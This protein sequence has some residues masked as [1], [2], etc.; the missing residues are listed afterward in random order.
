MR[1]W[2]VVRALHTSAAALAAPRR[3]PPRRAQKHQ[4]DTVRTPSAHT[5]PPPPRPAPRAAD[6]PRAGELPALEFDTPAAAHDGERAFRAPPLSEGLLSM[7]HALLGRRARPTRPQSQALAHFFDTPRRAG[8]TVVAAETGS[9]KTLAYLLP[10]LQL[11]HTTRAA[12]E[13]AD[14]AAV[15]AGAAPRLMPRAVVLAPTHELARQIA[16][17]AKALCHHAEHKLRVDC[18]STRLFDERAA[19]AFAQLEGYA[20]A[21]HDVAAPAHHGAPLS[22]DVL[23]TTPKRLRE[24][25][26]TQHRTPVSLANAQAVVVDEADT[27]LDEGFR[28]DT[29]AVL[30][31]VRAA[32]DAEVLFATATIPR[33]VTAYLDAAFPTRT[34]LASPHLHKL[35]ARLTARFVDPGGSKDMAILKELFRIFTTPTC[36]DDQVLIFRDRRTSVEQLSRFLRERN[37]DHVAFT[38]DADARADR[39]DP[40]LARFLHRPYATP[41]PDADAPRVLI[42]TSVLS[43]GLDFGPHLRHVFVPDAGRRGRTSVHNAN[44]NALELLHRAGRSARAGRPGTVVLFDKSSAPGHSK[45]LI[46]RR[47]QKKGVIRG[48]MDLLVRELKRPRSRARR[49]HAP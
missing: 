30:D 25:C 16:E 28:P 21:A 3:A 18:T 2:S 8:A 19:R 48:Q 11:L 14:Y 45:V 33:S 5:P 37:V 4:L 36:A 10:V 13:H 1:P 39:T 6:A 32:R 20:A 24:L 43:R 22:P 42:T 35:P 34:T 9:G 29:T 38:G 12:H 17:V 26:D 46:N 49:A 23:V 31:A 41:P 47:G 27:L 44:H 40:R 7:V 15:A